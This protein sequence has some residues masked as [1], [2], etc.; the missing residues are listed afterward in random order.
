[1]DADDKKAFAEVVGPEWVRDTPC[2][3]DTY[4]FYMNPEILNKDGS[5]WLPRPAAVLMPET[6]AEVSGIMKLCNKMDYMAKPLSTGFHCVAAASNEKVIVLDLKRMNKIVDLDLKNQI[7]VVEPYVKAINLQT[8]LWKE[9]LNLHVI[10]CGGNHSPLASA[11]SAWGTGLDGPSMSYS[12]RNLL[13]VEWVLP[14]GDVL[15]L[16]SAGEG[17]GAGWFTADGPGPSLR[18]IMRGYMG[19]FGGLGVFTK[20]AIK[21]YPWDGPSEIKVEGGCPRYRLTDDLPSNMG[22]FAVSFPA[23]KSL[24]DAGYKMGE[25]E[26]TYADFRLPA[27][28]T[29][30]GATEDNLEL[31]KI[32][33]SG[34]L[35]KIAKYHMIVA[36]IGGSQREYDWKYDTFKQILAETGGVILPLNQQP[37]ADQAE[38]V[39]KLLKYIDDPLKLFRK[40]PSLQWLIQKMPGGEPQRKKALSELFWVMLRHANN[41]QGNFRP[42]QAM[43][44]SLGTFDTWDLGLTQSEWIAER[45][46]E[47]IRQGLFLDDGGDLSCGGTFEHCHMGYLEGIVLYSS[48]DPKSVMAAGKIIDEAVQA[49]IDQSFGIPIA[50]FGSEMNAKLGPHCGNYHQWLAKIKKALD[51][52]VASDPFFYSKH[53]PESG[54][55]DPPAGDQS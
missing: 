48:K 47:Y 3:M 33:Q 46:Q 18:G 27:F 41:T 25:C 43:C 49:C 9:G 26:I 15:T 19:A 17:T 5:Q 13:G 44:T 30:M 42:S 11:T 40:F 55:G 8:I 51:P 28:Y 4:A 50:G 29:S 22:L 37:R 31:K 45:K 38:L 36:I 53:P 35:Q 24:A 52:N 2:M 39:G 1:M 14:T 21:L 10:S 6:T 12:G 32:W 34:L 23:R 20:A 54:N 16:G 7:A